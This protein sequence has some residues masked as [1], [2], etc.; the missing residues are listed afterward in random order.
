MK[1]TRMKIIRIL[2]FA[3]LLAPLV[4][5]HA[6]E[7]PAT[8]SSPVTRLGAG[9]HTRTITVGNLQRR[10]RVHVPKIYDAGHPRR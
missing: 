10:Y 7:P 5:L 9:E 1:N 3:L 6:A 4:T 2:I 8:S